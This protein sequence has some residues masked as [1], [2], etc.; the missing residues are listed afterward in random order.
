MNKICKLNQYFLLDILPNIGLLRLYIPL[1]TLMLLLW[2]C[3]D[4]VGVRFILRLKTYGLYEYF[5]AI[6]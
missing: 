3:G 6:L 4:L 5:C 2:G 1:F